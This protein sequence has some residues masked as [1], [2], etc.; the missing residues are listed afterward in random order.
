MTFY[1]IFLLYHDK[2]G[3]ITMG[4]TGDATD[5]DVFAPDC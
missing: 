5:Q 4:S 2:T 3:Q 1:Y